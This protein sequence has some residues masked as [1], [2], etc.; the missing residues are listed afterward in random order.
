MTKIS[1]TGELGSGK[2]TIAKILAEEFKAQYLST[3][4]I[5]RNIA[6]RFGLN[7]L[8]LNN[9]AD[10]NKLIDEEIDGTLKEL[11]NSDKSFV[12]DSR[13]AWFFIPSSFKLFFLIDIEIAARRVLNDSSRINEI[14]E[15]VEDTMQSLRERKKSENQRFLREYNADCADF[16]NFDFIINTTELKTMS[17]ANFLT[18]KI[19]D[20]K[21]NNSVIWCSPKILFPSIHQATFSVD[22]KVIKESI[23]KET[24]SENFP[25]SIVESNGTWVIYD[26]HKRVSVAIL[27]NIDMIP[28]QLLAKNEESFENQHSANDF[29]TNHLDKN[30][31]YIWEELHGFKFYK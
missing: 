29:I 25:I 30:N 13:L 24:F 22:S 5:Q 12:I 9:L 4:A 28:V 1:I 20:K 21:S 3:G 23:E 10:T 31:I 27:L 15:S 26:G 18:K 19:K 8:Q 7:T 6:N 17:I 16:K 2:S 11:N 14:Y